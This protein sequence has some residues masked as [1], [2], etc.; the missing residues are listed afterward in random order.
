[1]SRRGARFLFFALAGLLVPGA[2]AF[3]V[4]SVAPQPPVF[5]AGNTSLDRLCQD[6]PTADIRYSDYFTSPERDNGITY[7]FYN[8][9]ID[10]ADNSQFGYALLYGLEYAAE[11]AAPEDSLAVGIYF[12]GSKGKIFLIEKKAFLEFRKKKLTVEKLLLYLTVK[13]VDLKRASAPGATVKK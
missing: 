6:K 9:V 5:P 1:M 3:S 10:T 2:N 7:V 13:E 8:N 11:K 12:S 4:P